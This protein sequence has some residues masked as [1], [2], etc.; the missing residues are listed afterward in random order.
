MKMFSAV[1][2]LNLS[3]TKITFVLKILGEGK[4][5]GSIS[6]YWKERF[7]DQKKFNVGQG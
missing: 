3:F 7:D 4:F 2:E 1:N 6:Y 5:K